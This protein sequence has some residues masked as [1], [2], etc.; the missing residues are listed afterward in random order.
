MIGLKWDFD[1]LRSDSR[2]QD[3]VRHVGVPN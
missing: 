3:L 2:F 1:S